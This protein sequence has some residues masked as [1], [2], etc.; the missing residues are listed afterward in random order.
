MRGGGGEFVPAHAGQGAVILSEESMQ[1]S[2]CFRPLDWT[3]QNSPVITT[4]TNAEHIDLP[5]RSCL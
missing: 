5:V 1:N 2:C 4:V 3:Q